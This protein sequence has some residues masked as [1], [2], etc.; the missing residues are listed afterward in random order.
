MKRILIHNIQLLAG[1]VFLKCKSDHFIPLLWT[2]Q[3]LPNALK[4]Q[5]PDSRGLVPSL[6]HFGLSLS[7]CTT[8]FSVLK[9]GRFYICS[10]LC[11][12]FLPSQSCHQIH[13]PHTF[14]SGL[15]KY[16]TDRTLPMPAL[17]GP[18]PSPS[19]LPVFY[20]HSTYHS[21]Y[22]FVHPLVCLLLQFT[23]LSRQALCP[24]CLPPSSVGPV[25]DTQ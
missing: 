14:P 17:V 20:F 9:S 4:N 8:P 13:T 25:I 1:A 7:P 11:L 10:F 24:I 21:C 6:P 12:E 16:S 5:K 23:S 19:I 22:L 18:L 3:Q 2:L 15:Y